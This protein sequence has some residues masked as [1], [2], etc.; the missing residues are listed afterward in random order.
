MG[1]ELSTMTKKPGG[2]SQGD[3]SRFCSYLLAE[4]GLSLNT[5]TSYR[6]D[7]TALAV[8]LSARG[9]T[10]RKANDRLIKGYFQSLA[11][12]NRATSSIARAAAAIRAF[13]SFLEE[14]QIVQEN[15]ARM[16]DTPRLVHNLPRYLNVVQVE[17]LI[18]QVQGDSPLRFRDRAMLELAY[19][20]GL[21]ATELVSLD[22]GD[23]QLKEQYLRCWGKGG[24]ERIIPMGAQ[25]VKATDAWLRKGR[26][27]FIVPGSTEQAL[28]VNSRGKRLT[29]Q[30]FWHIIKGYVGSA[31]L[32]KD[33]SPHTLRHSF[34]THLL[35]GGANLRTVQELLGH[36]DYRYHSNIYPGNSTIF[37]ESVPTVSSSGS[38]KA[39]RRRGKG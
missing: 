30:G 24:K 12:G 3:I 38:K 32:P 31:Q 25:A 28:F 4:Q 29:R 21:R 14:E 15:P 8:Y 2:C 36:A 34:A 18:D 22:L 37:A 10:L 17:V 19:A 13:Y 35:E 16:I 27:L 20:C 33:I 26:R 39:T 1:K 5:V 9:D 11:R 23:V 7:L 6:G